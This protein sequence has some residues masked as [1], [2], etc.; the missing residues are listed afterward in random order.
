MHA[1]QSNTIPQMFSSRVAA[2]GDRR[3]LL[4]KKDGEFKSLTW[5]EVSREARLL[6]AALAK[7]GVK[8]GDRVVQ[9]SENRFEWILLDLAVHMARGIHVAV[10]STLTGPQIAWQIANC[11]AKI[12][13]VSGPEQGQK[14]AAA[15]AEIPKDVKFV[16]FDKWDGEIHG[17][18]V[19]QISEI[20]ATCTEAD[21]AALEKQAV[22]ETT[23]DDLVTILYTSGTTGE[24][25]GVMLSHRNL[26]SNC[27]AVMLAFT[28]EPDD[29]RLSWLPLSHIF[30]RTSDY[31]LWV[32]AGG[33]LALCASR[34]EIIP[35]CQA[36]KPHYLNGV[37]YFFDKVMRT[38]HD[39]GL[40][41]APGALKA[42]FGGRV[43]MCCAGGAAFADHVNEFF[44]KSG[45]TLVQGYGLTESSPVIST[46]TMSDH[47]VGTVGR[48][49]D[50]VEV[51]IAEDGEILT[52]GPHVMV[53]YWNMP[54]DTAETIRDGWLHTGDLGEIQDGFLRITGRKKEL[55]V[56]A[57]GKNIAPT[58]IEGLLTEDPLIIQAAV[59]GDAEKYLVALIVPDPDML[60]AEIIK[61]QIPVFTPADALA[62]PEVNAIYAERIKERLADVSHAEQVQRFKLLSRGFTPETGELTFKLSLKRDAVKENFAKE[63]D[64]MYDR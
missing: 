20:T 30:A 35:D 49:I 22:A 12:V 62:H 41:E 10:H 27:Q 55:I 21:G 14:L 39:K 6:A 59:F 18:S 29:V 45:L 16:S 2:D 46:G 28:A 24:P 25:K 4:F 38:L 34:E 26:T 32:C 19:Q 7:L 13:V 64:S 54:E 44:K 11:G 58:Y 56:T 42:T 53:G 60:R 40:A 47:R 61:R 63:I 9:A 31:Y 51:K 15:A 17:H 43:K 23:A 1:Q 5:N 57:G 36:I 8:P 52:R 50:G 3:A 33:E 37:P 48:P